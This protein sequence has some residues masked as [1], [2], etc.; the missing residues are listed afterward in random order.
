MKANINFIIVACISIIICMAS[1]T[2][3]PDINS[4]SKE[5]LIKWV[6]EGS[7]STNN[8]FIIRGNR[9]WNKIIHSDKFTDDEKYDLIRSEIISSCLANP[10]KNRF[11][12]FYFETLNKEIKNFAERFA[13]ELQSE[14]SKDRCFRDKVIIGLGYLGYGGKEIG[15]ELIKIFD[16]PSGEFRTLAVEATRLGGYTKFYSKEEM[17]P[18]FRRLAKDEYFIINKSDNIKK[19]CWGKE[20][21][22]PVR[23][24]LRLLLMHYKVKFKEVK[25]DECSD[26]IELDE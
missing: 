23:S 12:R 17:M 20:K 4:A 16:S 3:F 1:K 21:I 11:G 14:E 9:A 15:D 10:S 18:Y 24:Q 6:K 13:K 22:F 19:D 7:M 25:I 2:K 26:T 8:Y 5:E